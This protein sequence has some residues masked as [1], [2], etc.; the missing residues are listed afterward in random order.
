MLAQELGNQN[1]AASGPGSREWEVFL[2][3]RVSTLGATSISG[4]GKAIHSSPLSPTEA[5]SVQSSIMSGGEESLKSQGGI[6]GS[7]SL[8]LSSK[9]DNH[10]SRTMRAH[11]SKF[12]LSL[13][14]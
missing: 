1:L 13:F 10:K 4:A 8:S 12:K 9:A 14:R 3:N 2:R 11:L 7:E 6:D 5:V